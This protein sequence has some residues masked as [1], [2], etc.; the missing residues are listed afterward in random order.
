MK[1]YLVAL[2]VFLAV[3]LLVRA[4]DAATEEQLNRLRSE[5]SALQASNVELQKTV[6]SL[7]RDL[8]DLREQVS[9]PQGNFADAADV[10]KLAEKI[11]EVDHNRVADRELILKEVKKLA[12]TPPVKPPG[13]NQSEVG[14]G[15]S[16]GQPASKEKGYEYTVQAGDTLSTIV[17]AYRDQNVKVTVDQVLKANPGLKE[18]SLKVGQKIFIPAAK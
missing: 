7:T 4:Q 15:G 12:N 3:P 1:R 9:K 10:N 13:G 14:A 11:S 18:K 2:M 16:S 5:V 6:A 8:A 17:Q